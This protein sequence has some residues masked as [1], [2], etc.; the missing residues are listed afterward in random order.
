MFSGNRRT[1]RPRVLACVATAEVEQAE[2]LQTPEAP[3]GPTEAVER[4]EPAENF[5]SRRRAR[6]FQ[7]RR[8]KKEKI[9]DI[10]DLTVGQEVEAV[11]V[12]LH[13]SS[14]PCL[15]LQPV[16]KCVTEAAPLLLAGR[17]DDVWCLRGL[18]C[19][20][21]RADPHLSADGELPLDRCLTC[22]RFQ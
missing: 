8:P 17:C 14:S 4:K 16:A 9:Y 3:A 5:E 12:R 21:G 15:G 20:K 18:W 11:V 6:P 13:S 19:R 7:Q 10:T 1:L 22:H 2:E